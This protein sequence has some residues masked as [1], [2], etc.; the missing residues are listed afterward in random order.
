MIYT[1]SQHE[2]QN[3]NQRSQISNK[4][5]FR[6]IK[7]TGTQLTGIDESTNEGNSPPWRLEMKSSYEQIIQKSAILKN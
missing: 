7:R 5:D 3:G 6:H 1:A 2:E 4:Q